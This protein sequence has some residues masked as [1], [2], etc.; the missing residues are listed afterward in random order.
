MTNSKQSAAD[1]GTAAIA[2]EELMRQLVRLTDSVQQLARQGASTPQPAPPPAGAQPDPAA[3]ERRKVL[4]A[5][6]YLGQVLDRRNFQ[7]KRVTVTR[8]AD[9]LTFTDLNGGVS[10]RLRSAGNR[11][12]TL[13]G[14]SEGVQVD[15]KEI[16]DDDRIDAFL[17]LDGQGVP[18]ALGNCLDRVDNGDGGID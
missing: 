12:E 15:L 13:T 6:D 1:T 18:V 4:F 9:G 10:A 2:P 3:D 5:Y 7:L 16:P 8:T 14:L 11:T 17:V